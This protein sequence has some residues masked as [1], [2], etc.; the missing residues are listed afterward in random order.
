MDTVSLT[1]DDAFQ[2][3]TKELNE[4][5]ILF[6]KWLSQT[7]GG[8]TSDFVTFRS[9]K[10]NIK[11]LRLKKNELVDMKNNYQN[12]LMFQSVRPPETLVKIS[13]PRTGQVADNRVPRLG[14]KGGNKISLG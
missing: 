12:T 2:K 11:L 9:M 14:Q 13:K 8:P 5:M 1:I 4:A 3:T 7:P 6:D 10:Q